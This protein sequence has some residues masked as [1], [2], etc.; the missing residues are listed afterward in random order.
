MFSLMP[1]NETCANSNLEVKYLP[2]LISD[3]K[4]IFMLR[5]FESWWHVVWYEGTNVSEKYAASNLTFGFVCTKN[6]PSDYSHN[7]QGN[8]LNLHHTGNSK[9]S[10]KYAS[11][12][13]NISL[14]PY[15]RIQCEFLR[16]SLYKWSMCKFTSLSLKKFTPGGTEEQ[17]LPNMS[18]PYTVYLKEPYSNAKV[19]FEHV[20]YVPLAMQCIYKELRY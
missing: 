9:P 20:F 19:Q 2:D 4:I 18:I 6:R 17:I 16:N 3:R 8:N 11:S 5:S 7:P 15:N 10:K 13:T 14:R 12:Y 1:V